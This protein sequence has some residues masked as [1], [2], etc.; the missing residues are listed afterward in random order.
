MKRTTLVLE[1]GCMDRIRELARRQG[2]TMSELVN[3]ILAEGLQRRRAKRPSPQLPSFAMGRPR[4]DV[5]DRDA[6]EAVMD[7]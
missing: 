4:V 7:D 3:E 6:L 5:A 2:R 1:D